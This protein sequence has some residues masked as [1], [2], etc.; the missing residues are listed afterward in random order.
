MAKRMKPGCSLETNHVI[1]WIVPL[2]RPFHRIG[3][4][5]A[6]SHADA[7]ALQGKPCY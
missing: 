1:E 7:G 4:A 5:C 2:R 6:A 3:V